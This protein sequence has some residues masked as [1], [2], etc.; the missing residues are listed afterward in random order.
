MS[1]NTWIL[2]AELLGCLKKGMRLFGSN[3]APK[4]FN[5]EKCADEP[6]HVNAAT[7]TPTS[8]S[9]SRQV[10]TRLA[11]SF[12]V[13]PLIRKYPHGTFQLELRD[14]TIRTSA[15]VAAGSE[16][17]WT[18]VPRSTKPLNC[19]PSQCT[20]FQMDIS[21]IIRLQ[22]T[23]FLIFFEAITLADRAAK[24]A[25]VN[26]GSPSMVLY[27]ERMTDGWGSPRAKLFL[28]NLYAFDE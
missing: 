28:T 10:V 11:F 5:I 13:I 18:F 15:S 14:T 23:S 27:Q 17:S 8:Y 20:C 7:L 9:F 25:L 4:D 1:R 16:S 22:M 26:P 21:S 3:L 2:I 6:S 12:P 19:F 24:A